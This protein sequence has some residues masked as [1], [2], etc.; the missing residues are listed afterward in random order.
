MRSFLAL[1]ILLL[2]SCKSYISYSP[3]LDKEELPEECTELYD[4][5]EDNWVRHRK[6]SCHK[7]FT[8]VEAFPYRFKDC[9]HN[10]DRTKIEKLFGKPDE[11]EY[12]SYY[13]LFKRDCENKREL[14]VYFFQVAFEGDKV[15][16]VDAG[17]MDYKEIK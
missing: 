13:Y 7:F 10:L 6:L 4:F 16:R 9:L 14:G 11:V 5:V 3:K 8:K 17:E 2:I 12:D 15:K 1:S